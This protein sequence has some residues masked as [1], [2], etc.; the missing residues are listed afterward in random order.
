MTYVSTTVRFRFPD[1]ISASE[2][3]LTVLEDARRTDKKYRITGLSPASI[4][5]HGLL[6][7]GEIDEIS[8]K[9]SAISGATR[10]DS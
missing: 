4:L 10:H 8:E 5:T 7:E 2:A 9:L 6:L 3:L 1:Y